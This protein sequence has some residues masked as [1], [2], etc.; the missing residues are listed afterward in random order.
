MGTEPYEAPQTESREFVI[1][2]SKVATTPSAHMEVR[3][4]GA[5]STSNGRAP[6]HFSIREAYELWAATYDSTPNPLLALEARE[7]VP[8]LPRIAGKYV[9]DIACGTG[10]WLQRLLELGAAGGAGIDFSSAM[11]AIAATKPDLKGRLVRAD[12]LSPPFRSD[13]ADLIVC[14]FALAHLPELSGFVDELARLARCGAD[15][16]MTDV[17]PEGYKAGWRSSFRNGQSVVEIPT[18]P[19]SLAQIE[20]AFEAGGFKVAKCVE[21]HF[22]DVDRPIFVQAKKGY[23]FEAVRQIP[24]VLICHFTRSHKTRLHS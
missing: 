19:R 8:L 18:Y 16:Y 22:E 6:S 12:C 14:S 1:E 17:H 20:R 23:V 2:N 7:L 3:A 5:V 21:P 13:A 10:R 11:L 15:L 4:D 24:A 9:F